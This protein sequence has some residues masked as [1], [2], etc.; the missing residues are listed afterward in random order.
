MKNIITGWILSAIGFTIIVFAIAYFFGYHPPFMPDEGV[1][2][3]KAFEILIA[4]CIGVGL[5][6]L[7][8]TVLEKK[9]TEVLE[10]INISIIKKPKPKD[11]NEESA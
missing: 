3:P 2:I 6:L 5:L 10:S 4:F 7:P 1:F 11:D 8:A 9:A